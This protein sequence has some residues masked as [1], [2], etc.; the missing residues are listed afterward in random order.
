MKN[1]YCKMADKLRTEALDALNR[2]Y[3]VHSE[4][5]EQYNV[6]GFPIEDECCQFG[7]IIY[8]NGMWEL[9]EHGSGNIHSVYSIP[10]QDLCEIVDRIIEKD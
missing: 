10:L 8:L 5:N 3:A 6:L 4:L 9:V 1:K 7:F 2:I